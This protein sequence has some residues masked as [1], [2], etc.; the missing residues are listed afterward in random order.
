MNRDQFNL[1]RQQPSMS[2][3]GNAAPVQGLPANRMGRT[4]SAGREWLL[5]VMAE[6]L[7]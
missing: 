6:W 1:K 2:R 3:Y 7:I 4:K 5:R